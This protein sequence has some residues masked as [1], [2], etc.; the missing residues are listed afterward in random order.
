MNNINQLIK[1]AQEMQAKFMDAQE[2]ISKVDILGDAGGG[3]VTVVIGGKGEAK[4]VTIDPQLMVPEEA[5][6]VA[7]LV[8][9]AFN[10]AKEKLEIKI[11]EEMGIMLPPGMKLF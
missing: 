6:V 7:D 10:N 4:K 9:V 5:E 2:K 1:Q 11:R 3:M 8:V